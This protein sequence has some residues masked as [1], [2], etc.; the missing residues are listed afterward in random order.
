MNP[1]SLTDDEGSPA[2]YR[3]IIE[4]YNACSFTLT[5]VDPTTFK[6]AAKD[7]GWFSAMQEEMEAVYKNKP[8]N[9]RSCWK[10]RRPS[11]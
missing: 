5:I 11:A 7:K 6:D 9:C 10:E 2:R 1:L 4:I 8:G 3:N